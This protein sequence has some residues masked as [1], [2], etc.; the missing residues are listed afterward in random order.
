MN[1]RAVVPDNDKLRRKITASAHNHAMVGHPGIKGTLQLVA[2]NYWWPRMVDFVTGYV[3]GCARCQETKASMN[4]PKL[5]IY[6]ITA[7]PAAKPFKTISLDLIVDLPPLSGYDLILTVTDHDMSKA[8]LFFPCNQTIG[9][10]GIATIFANHVFPHFR[11]PHKVI[12]NRDTHLTAQF[13]QELCHLL[14]VTQNISTAYHPQTD[15]QSERIN[16]WLEQYLQVYCNFQQDDWS[17]LLPMA[18]YVHNL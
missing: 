13:T 8:A 1:G 9:A 14:D 7:E 5:P 16:Q 10:L 11:I 4:K 18:Q 6:P 12:S 17:S 15:G 3:K 2:R